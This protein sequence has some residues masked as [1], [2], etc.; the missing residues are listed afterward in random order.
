MDIAIFIFITC[1][2][3]ILALL[4]RG[5]ARKAGWMRKPVICP[6]RRRKDRI[7]VNWYFKGEPR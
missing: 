1:Q 3:A 2:L 6:P 5:L 7:R 4:L